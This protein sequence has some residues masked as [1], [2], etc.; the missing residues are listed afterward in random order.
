MKDLGYGLTVLLF[1]NAVKFVYLVK[2]Q[3]IIQN[4][5]RNITINAEIVGDA[6]IFESCKREAKTAGVKKMKSPTI[7]HVCSCQDRLPRRTSWIR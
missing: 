1:H 3:Y 2:R 5:K 4:P 6:G 7:I